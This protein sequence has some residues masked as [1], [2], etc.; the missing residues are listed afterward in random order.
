MPSFRRFG[1]TSVVAAAGA[2]RRRDDAPQKNPASTRARPAALI[3]ADVAPP[4][5]HVTRT[6]ILMSARG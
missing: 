6:W 4:S 2:P 5:S 3:A 1:S